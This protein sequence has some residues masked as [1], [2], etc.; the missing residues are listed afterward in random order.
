MAVDMV[1]IVSPGLLQAV[2][3]I[4]SKTCLYLPKKKQAK[5]VLQFVGTIV[6][7]G[8][9]TV[10]ISITDGG[11]LSLIFISTD[12]I[13]E[14]AYQLHSRGEKI[15]IAKTV[16]NIRWDSKVQLHKFR[17]LLLAM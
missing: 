17:D 9:S 16:Q 3:S 13:K 14:K 4:V 8:Q 5:T 15:I 1:H 11:I 10:F 7:M 2:H 6:L 12:Q